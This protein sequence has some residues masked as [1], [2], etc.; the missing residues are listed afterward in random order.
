VVCY[1]VVVCIVGWNLRSWGG[2]GRWLGVG[3][4]AGVGVEVR[5][6][7]YHLVRHLRYVSVVRC[8]SSVGVACKVGLGVGA[9]G[10]DRDENVLA[11]VRWDERVL[12]CSR[13]DGS[14]A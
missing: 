14:A 13:A 4:G 7:I 1:L 8:H 10:R 3:F 5:L 2:I 6:A 11:E 12:V 9:V